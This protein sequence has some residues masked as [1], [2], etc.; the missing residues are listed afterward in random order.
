[1][2]NL[3]SEWSGGNL[4]FVPSQDALDASI[5]PV[6]QV[7]RTDKPVQAK[8][9]NRPATTGSTVEVR[10]RPSS[11]TATHYA[12]DSTLDWRPTTD[13]TATGGG[14]RAVQGVSRM[15]AGY[16]TTGGDLT[17]VYGQVAL[18]ATATANGAGVFM[19]ALYGLVEDGGT[20]TAVSHLNSCWLDSHLTS[21]VT[22]GNVEL[23][24]MTHNGTTT[25]QNAIYI[26][27]GNHITNLFTIDTASG[28]VS[29]NTAA[30]TTLTFTNWRTIKVVVAGETHY[31]PVAKTIAAT[32]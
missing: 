2:E 20:Y 28:M 9:H 23:L 3:T 30:A 16:T 12:V 32:G 11:V 26:Y 5:T 22:A 14:C 13:S 27:A 17:G 25:M 24:Y 10:S 31:I 19:S 8:F 29:D 21:A 15:D 18:N 7:G 1:M 6:F 4:V